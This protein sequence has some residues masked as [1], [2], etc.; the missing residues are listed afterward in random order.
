MSIKNKLKEYEVA[1]SSQDIQSIVS[2]FSD[3][4]SFEDLPLELKASN[5]QELTELLKLTFE[6]I[7][8]FTMEIFEVH[9][10]DNFLVTKW[11]QSGNITV[12]GYGLDLKNH[13]YQVV[14]TSIIEFNEKGEITSVSDNWDTG[15]FY[16]G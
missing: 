5:K 16:Q 4:L 10:S 7:P 2:F 6:G 11:K 9:E 12:N 15:I 8:N 3:D 13:P 14:T 1:W